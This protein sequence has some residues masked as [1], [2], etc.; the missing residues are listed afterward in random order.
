MRKRR[1]I[2][3][4]MELSVTGFKANTSHI[5]PLFFIAA[6]DDPYQT[7]LRSCPELTNLNFVVSKPTHSTT[8]HIEITGAPV[9]SRHCLLPADKLKAAKAEFNHTLLVSDG[10]P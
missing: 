4:N 1:L 3:A 2:D 8:H 5:S 9:F 7:L 6:I 10:K